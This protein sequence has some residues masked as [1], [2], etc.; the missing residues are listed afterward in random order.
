MAARRSRSLCARRS[1]ASAGADAP[2]VGADKDGRPNIL[3]VM[4]DD[5]A[6]PTSS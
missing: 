1:P 5:M 4:T 2:T 6:P 3:V